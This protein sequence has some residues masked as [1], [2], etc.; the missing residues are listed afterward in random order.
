MHVMYIFTLSQTGTPDMYT[1]ATGAHSVG[2]LEDSQQNKKV[3]EVS[4]EKRETYFMFEWQ[5]LSCWIYF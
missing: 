3:V 5:P 2:L 1:I 4:S